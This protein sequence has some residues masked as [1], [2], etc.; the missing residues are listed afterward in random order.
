MPARTRLFPVAAVLS[1]VAVGNARE[2]P[3]GTLSDVPGIRVGH[4]TLTERPTGCTVV[5]ADP[6]A[7]GAVDVRGGAPG[8][9]ETN[10]LDPVNTV[11]RVNAIVL[12]GGSAFGLDAATGVVKWL[13]EHGE[14]FE[15]SVARVPIVPAAILFDLGLG[16]PHIRPS[17]DCGYR[18]AAI[19]GSGPVAEGSVG[20]GAGATV[21]KLMGLSRAMKSGIG[22]ASVATSAGLVVGAIAAVNSYGDVI[23]PATGRVVAGLRTADGR[24]L[25]DARRVLRANAGIADASGENTTLVVVATNAALTKAQTSKVAQMAQDGLARAIAPV[26]TP[27]DGDTVFALATGGRTQK[28]DVLIV[29]ALAADVTALAIVR[30]VRQATTAGGV[31]ALRDLPH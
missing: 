31:P 13:E 4:H 28:D 22:T 15:T 23:D 20:A 11:D 26:H 9:R 19:A 21:G 3:N 14:G 6:P 18:A 27:F 1:V 25:A 10:L 29:G 8:T 2:A 30:A 16:D 24:G 17:A 12:S 5:I 7:V